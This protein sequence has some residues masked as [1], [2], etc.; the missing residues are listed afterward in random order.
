MW[1][2]KS[3]WNRHLT[4]RRICR[5]DPALKEPGDAPARLR[6]ALRPAPVVHSRSPRRCCWTSYRA[7][8]AH[9][10]PAH[11][12]H[13]P[14]EPDR[15]PPAGALREA[16]LPD[17]AWDQSNGRRNNRRRPRLSVRILVSRARGLGEKRWFPGDSRR[18]HQPARRAGAGAPALPG[19]PLVLTQPEAHR[20]VL[21]SF[22]LLPLLINSPS[23]LQPIIC[24]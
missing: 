20:P 16:S 23:K 17:Q 18:A 15:Q 13:F 2:T 12:A 3:D 7:R 14:R 6:P 10:A 8:C 9:T 11:W 5:A 19:G 4:A 21:F 24:S 22:Q 1:V